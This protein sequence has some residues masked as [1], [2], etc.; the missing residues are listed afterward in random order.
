MRV[1]WQQIILNLR[2]AGMTYKEI[3]NRIGVDAQTIGHL[4]RMEIYEPKFSKGLALLNLHYDKCPDKHN[5]MSLK[6]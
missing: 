1:D 4:A 3:S 2:S 5:G 6:L